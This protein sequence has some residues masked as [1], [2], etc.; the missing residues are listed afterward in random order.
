MLKPPADA[1]HLRLVRNADPAPVP[2]EPERDP[3][4]GLMQRAGFEVA[5]E[6]AV[7]E[8][9]DNGAAMA[10][11]LLDFP[12]F[13][14][15]A[16]GVQRDTRLAFLR[17]TG[18][19]LARHAGP[20]GLAARLDGARFAL[21]MP[22]P[23]VV[24]GAT[25]EAERLS[26]AL[27]SRQLLFDG[28][29]AQLRPRIGYALTPDDTDHA[30]DVLGGHETGRH[31]ERFAETAASL[32]SCADLALEHAVEGGAET[33]MRFS[34][35]LVIARRRL[36]ELG[37]A[38]G[39][40][41]TSGEVKVA[42]QPIMDIATMRL[43]GFEALL[44]WRHP[45]FGPVPPPEAVAVAE[46]NDAMCA[47]TRHVMGEAVA[48]CRE[49]PD[50]LVFAV[51]VTP[52]QLNDHLVALIDSVLTSSG[53]APHRLEIEVTEDALIR[54]V[55]AS[56]KV[57]DAIRK[58]GARVAM[59]DFG[60]GFTSLRNLRQLAFDKIKIDRSL[61]EGL[62]E[63]QRTD[64]IVSGLV[65][66]AGTLGIDATVEGVETEE[67]LAALAGLPCQ[68]QGYVFSPPVPPSGME[69]FRPLLRAP[70]RSRPAA[71]SAAS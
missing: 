66:L 63:N 43:A 56:A 24:E 40:A 50:D 71:R 41:I 30:L 47:L 67:Q 22:T 33:P 28:T 20:S 13:T 38:I 36:A 35:A 23:R 26:D 49:W 45:E 34:P 14:D 17:D 68:V 2:S 62:G 11:Y 19:P 54:D 1:P 37:R 10:L 8:R 16:R 31:V 32:S 27:A 29:D 59:D 55:E 58:L 18:E 4:T 42:F 51:N 12:Q 48:R 69:V 44:R 25:V 5:L 53:V 39:P 64:A 70:Q 57:I 52:S 61:C 15:I 65:H 9:A 6:A 46:Q 3:V 7:A 60:A 21:L